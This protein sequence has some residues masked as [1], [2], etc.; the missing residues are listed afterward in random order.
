M[1]AP[2]AEGSHHR[3]HFHEGEP[4]DYDSEIVVGVALHMCFVYQNGYTA[5]IRAS[6][7][8]FSLETTKALLAAGADKEAKDTVGGDAYEGRRVD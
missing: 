1:G 4:A 5:L 8:G 3:S 2:R 7:S 6:Y